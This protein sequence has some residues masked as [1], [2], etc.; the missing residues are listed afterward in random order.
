MLIDCIGMLPGEVS[1]K[2]RGKHYVRCY[3]YVR[4]VYVRCNLYV[5]YVFKNYAQ[6]CF[7]CALDSS[8]QFVFVARMSVRVFAWTIYDSMC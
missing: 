5:R 4:Y 2:Y 3:V 1:M 7:F 6:R 8:S